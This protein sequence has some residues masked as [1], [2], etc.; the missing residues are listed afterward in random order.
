MDIYWKSWSLLLVLV[1]RQMATSC[2]CHAWISC[3]NTAMTCPCSLRRLRQLHTFVQASDDDRLSKLQ[4][5]HRFGS[6]LGIDRNKKINQIQVNRSWSDHLW[7]EQLRHAVM[8]FS[9]SFELSWIVFGGPLEERQR[10]F[11]RFSVGRFSGGCSHSGAAWD[12]ID[13][14]TPEIYRNLT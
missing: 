11:S 14:Y 1:A 9:S 3:R 8:I 10:V 2:W 6:Y 7:H 13:V 5:I 4:R 12:G